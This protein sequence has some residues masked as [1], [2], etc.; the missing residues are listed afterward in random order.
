MLYAFRWALV[1]SLWICFCFWRR[2]Q[3]HWI[4]KFSPYW[5]RQF[6]ICEF[7]LPGYLKKSRTYFPQS[8]SAPL[9][10][11]APP[12]C[13]GPSQREA[14]LT[15]RSSSVFLVTSDNLFLQL[16]LVCDDHHWH[17]LPHPGALGMG[18]VW[19]ALWHV[20]SQMKRKEEKILLLLSAFYDFAGSGV[21]H[22]G[23]GT[24]ALVG[25]IMLGPRLG[26][27]GP[28]VIFCWTKLT[29]SSNHWLRA[30]RCRAIR[31]LSLVSELSS[32][33]SVSSHLTAAHRAGSPRKVT[34]PWWLWPSPTPSWAASAAAWPCSLSSKSSRAGSGVW[35]NLLMAV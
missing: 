20:N 16:H 13:Q 4:W 6:K 1:L 33:F 24:C 23:G 34:A 9:L 10:P 17:H 5:C 18:P 27:F 21:V 8:F 2:K 25:A 14:I 3:F 28:N 7:F 32:S 22:L 31:C 19:L 30:S 35:S 29:E 15:G 11:P 26:R 12:L